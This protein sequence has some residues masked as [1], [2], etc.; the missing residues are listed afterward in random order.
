MNSER[1]QRRFP[2]TKLCNTGILLTVC[3]HLFLRPYRQDCEAKLAASVIAAL[4]SVLCRREVERS[5]YPPGMETTKS[6]IARTL[7]A[8]F[9]EMGFAAPG[10]DALRSGAEVSLRTLYK[11]Y[12]SREAMVIGALEHRNQIYLDWIAGGPDHGAAHVLHVFRRLGDWLD[13]VT[14]TGCLFLNAVAAYPEDPKVREAAARHKESVRQ[15]F[16]ARV[17]RVAPS[18]D[19]EAVSHGLMTIHEGQTSRAMIGSP[20]AATGAALSLARAL[21]AGEGIS[22]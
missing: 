20:C 2:K 6:K 22:E 14:N 10:V 11:Y 12:P 19:A 4:V 13:Q 17:A 21:L 3:G 15:E 16:E 5:L 1:P 7:E 8:Q 9:A 18:A